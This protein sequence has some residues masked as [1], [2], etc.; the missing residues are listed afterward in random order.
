MEKDSV[1]ESLLERLTVYQNVGLDAEG[2]SHFF[3]PAE[4]VIVVCGTDRRGMGVRESDIVETFAV[5]AKTVEAYC[6]FVRDET[7]TEWIECN[8]LG[9]GADR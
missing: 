6:W 8:W 2:R 1:A 3:E 5:G 4:R 9:A 7:D